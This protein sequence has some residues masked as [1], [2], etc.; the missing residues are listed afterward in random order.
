MRLIIDRL[1]GAF[2]VCED[3]NRN[4]VNIERS[5]LPPVAKEGDVLN[6]MGSEIK[7]NVEETETKKQKIKKMMGAVWK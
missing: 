4:M 2:A 6:V 7:I 1:E 5:R 3:D